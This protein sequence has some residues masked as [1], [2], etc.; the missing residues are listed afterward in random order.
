MHCGPRTGVSSA[1]VW[2]V[3][4]CRIVVIW[5]AT[6]STDVVQ[7][8]RNTDHRRCCVNVEQH[9]SLCWSSG[10]GACWR[11]RW[12]DSRLPDTSVHCQI[13]TGR[14]GQRSWIGLIAQAKVVTESVRCDHGATHQLQVAPWYFLQ[15][16]HELIRFLRWCVQRLRSKRTLISSPSW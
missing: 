9:T 3:Q 10:V 6:S 7:P 4:E 2:T 1:T 5:R 15:L 8:L 16:H 13:D 14:R 11:Q 12:A